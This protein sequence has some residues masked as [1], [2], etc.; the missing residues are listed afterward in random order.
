MQAGSSLKSRPDG[1]GGKFV[2]LAEA[3]IKTS[4]LEKRPAGI[5]AADVELAW[6]LAEEP[7]NPVCQVVLPA[8]SALSMVVTPSGSEHL[9]SDNA[10]S[11]VVGPGM[12]K[13]GFSKE[14][15]TATLVGSMLESGENKTEGTDALEMLAEASSSH[16]LSEAVGSESYVGMHRLAEQHP[17]I[18][19]ALAAPALQAGSQGDGPSSS[20]PTKPLSHRHKIPFPTIASTRTRRVRMPRFYDS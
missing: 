12:Q 2:T 17:E 16:G 10:D 19:S 13:A 1:E 11:L 5:T 4:L 6:A 3:G 18:A 9:L 20:Q 15:H 7:A 8:T 14:L